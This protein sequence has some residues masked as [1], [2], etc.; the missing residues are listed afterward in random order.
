MSTAAAG[1]SRGSS[2]S[3]ATRPTGQPRPKPPRA[4][5][6][7]V[8]AVSSEAPRAPFVVLVA[9]LL[10]AGLGG[11]LFLHTA[12]A[13]DSFKLHDLQ[14]RA[15]VLQDQQQALEQLLALEASPRRLSDRAQALGMVR[16]ENPA[17]IRLSD[18]RILG[19]PKAGVAPPPPPAPTTSPSSSPSPDAT[20]TD[21]KQ[22]GKQT[23]AGKKGNDKKKN[24]ATA[25]Q[26][27]TPRHTG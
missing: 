4:R 9:C 25:Q 14:V 15:S 22:T 23:D 1:T 7:L 24:N 17:F 27:P 11:L 3:K 8:P 19:K 6:L 10:V 5:L 16:S 12:L 21:G 18:G 13:E 2:A 26:S 20:P